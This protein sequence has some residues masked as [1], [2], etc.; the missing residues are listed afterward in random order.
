MMGDQGAN[1]NRAVRAKLDQAGLACDLRSSLWRECPC[2][3]ELCK[4]LHAV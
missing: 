1:V 2:P 4:R 3:H